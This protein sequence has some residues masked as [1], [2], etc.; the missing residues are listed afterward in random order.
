ME[1]SVKRKRGRR[2]NATGRNVYDQYAKFGYPMLQS[3]AWRSLSGAA[4]KI[5]VELR[6]RFNG[7]NNGRLSLSWDEAARTLG[8]GKATVGRAFEELLKKG[9]VVLEEKGHWYGRKATRW[10]LTFIQQEGCFPTHEWKQWVP[11]KKQ[12]LGSASDHIV[13]M[14]GPLENR[15]TNIWSATKPVSEQLGSTTGS[16]VDQ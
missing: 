13:S 14:T 9:F 3:A 1:K 6:T 4:I 11:P 8:I 5:L 7:G 10:R 12:S 16:K 15:D 2:V